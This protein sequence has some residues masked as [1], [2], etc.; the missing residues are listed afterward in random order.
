MDGATPA[1]EIGIGV[2]GDEEFGKVAD[3]KSDVVDVGQGGE[4]FEQTV[5]DGARDKDGVAAREKVFAIGAEEEDGLNAEVVDIAIGVDNPKAI[6]DGGE[7][8]A[9]RFG[10]FRQIDEAE[11]KAGARDELLKIGRD[12]G[13][14]GEDH[15]FGDGGG[16]EAEAGEGTVDNGELHTVVLELSYL[17][18]EDSGGGGS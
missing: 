9:K 7:L 14:S 12:S 2:G 10:D 17:L 15:S 16:G 13:A 4:E 11:D 8:R 18:T 1:R 5:A 6:V 3:N